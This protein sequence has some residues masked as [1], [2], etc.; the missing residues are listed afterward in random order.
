MDREATLQQEGPVDSVGLT[1]P[2]AIAN[3]IGTVLIAILLTVV[4]ASQIHAWPAAVAGVGVLALAGWVYLR[5]A[6]PFR[7]PVRRPTFV[8][9]LVLLLVAIVLDD[10]ARLGSLSAPGPVSLGGWAVAVVPL[11]LFVLAQVRPALELLIGGAALCAGMAT[12]A[13]ALS[14]TLDRHSPLSIALSTL[15]TAVPATIAMAA[16]VHI[17]VRA[18]RAVSTVDREAWAQSTEQRETQWERDVV[19]LLREVVESG[20]VTSG[21]GSRAKGIA[22]TLRSRLAVDQD[23]DW[24]SELGIAVEDDEGYG[25]RMALPQRITMRGLLAALPVTGPSDPGRARISGQDL[26]AVLELD[27][28]ITRRPDSSHLGPAVLMLRTAFPG[29]RF[30]V[31]DNR[32]RLTAEFSVR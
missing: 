5:A 14:P 23:R 21:T 12:T 19:K 6:S 13:I 2:F 31:D 3:L 4:Q 1:R 17:T 22:T 9:V 25:E 7:A 27:L 32:V 18:I 10:V 16:F 24:I 11:S 15:I 28:P 30:R 26:D 20:K 29:A 8:L